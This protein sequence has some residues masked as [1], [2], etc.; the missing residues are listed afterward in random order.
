MSVI[1]IISCLGLQHQLSSNRPIFHHPSVKAMSAD[2]E[3][4]ALQLYVQHS[5]GDLI[6]HAADP[7]SLTQEIDV[8]LD[9]YAPYIWGMDA[10][11]SHLLEVGYHELYTKY[12]IYE[13]DDDRKKL[14]LHL[15]QWI[16]ILAFAHVR[17]LGKGVKAKHTVNERLTPNGGS[18]KKS[19]LSKRPSD[20][21]PPATGNAG[22]NGLTVTTP[23]S[24]P[25]PTQD[26]S[27]LETSKHPGNS[28]EPSVKKQKTQ[29]TNPTMTGPSTAPN[30]SPAI[31]ATPSKLTAAFLNY[32]QVQGQ[33]EFIELSVL[34]TLEYDVS[35]LNISRILKNHPYVC[36]FSHVFTTW[37]KYRR[38][39]VDVQE[40]VQCAYEELDEV[41]QKFS[42]SRLMTD[43]R[44]A[45]DTF[46]SS[47]GAGI[48]AE[49]VICQGFGQMQR[50]VMEGEKLMKEVRKG[51]ARLDAQLLMLGNTLGDGNWILMG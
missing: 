2:I 16:F 13:L 22:R 46:R 19:V 49:D 44:K 40:R 48:S 21:P 23:M 18:E 24:S 5:L 14:W 47:A 42:Y 38:T 7:G 20:A 15:H 8:L 9:E 12:I 45:T 3:A 27:K 26:N 43:L 35:Q 25:L 10:D 11:T 51:F 50:T 34:D 6:N 33:M 31:G 36:I 29:H 41:E 4:T 39:I 17:E 32:M 28:H 1:D 30:P 37:I